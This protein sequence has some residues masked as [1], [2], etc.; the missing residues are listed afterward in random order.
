MNALPPVIPLANIAKWLPEIF[1]DGTANRNYVV[2]EIAAKTLFVMFYVGAVEA[3]GRWLRP[4]QVTRMTDRQ[5]MKTTDAAR[6]TWSL[7]SLRSGALRHQP[8]CWYAV[9][10]REPIR[11][12]TLRTGLVALGAVVERT[13][14]PTTSARPRYAIAHDFASLLI[15]LHNTP[16]EAAVA[17]RRWQEDHLTVSALSRIQLVRQGTVRSATHK[18]VKVTFP[19]GETRLMLP[20]PS[21]VIS[22][23]V[24][25]VFAPRFL[26]EPGVV[27]LS[28]S[29]NKVV[30][31]DET[32]A[33]AIGLRLDYTRNLP[34]IILA[35]VQTRGTRVVFVEAVATDGA[36]TEARKQALL[37][38]ASEAGHRQED[39]YFVSAF[40]DRGASA[41]RRLASELAWGSYAWFVSEPECIVLFSGAGASALP[42]LPI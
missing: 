38:V 40:R 32:L 9:D 11:D 34:D 2:R 14:L 36:V 30:Q 41:F 4:N 39:V 33:A 21:T 28:E 31:R 1:P 20:G 24:V 8:G 7:Q 42:G 16:H 22:K 3:L 10:T 23:A 25:E 27:F 17:I 29:G 18:R 5:A 15:H 12:E 6:E 37:Q 13:G 26:R 19:N 35:D